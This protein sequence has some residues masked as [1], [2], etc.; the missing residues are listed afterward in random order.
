MFFPILIKSLYHKQKTLPTGRQAPQL[1]VIS[2]APFIKKIYRRL[3]RW[4]RS[5]GKWT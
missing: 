3:K 5:A 1:E 2:L 4:L